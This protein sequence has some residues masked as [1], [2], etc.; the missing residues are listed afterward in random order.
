MPALASGVRAPEIR[1][2]FPDGTPFSLAEALKQGPVVAAFYKVSCPVCQFAFPYVERLYKAYGSGRGKTT[3]VGVSQDNAEAS[4][5]F[6]REF[7][8][9]FPSLLDEKGFPASNA[10]RLTN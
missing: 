10:Y 8:V 3:F 7:G 2:C 5:A 4:R 1:L 6:Q 9:S